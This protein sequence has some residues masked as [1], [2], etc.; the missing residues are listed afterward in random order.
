MYSY[1]YSLYSTHTVQGNGWEIP[2]NNN[3]TQLQA[4][5]AIGAHYPGVHGGPP[6]VD[7]YALLN[8]LSK[9]MW[10]SEDGAESM[11]SLH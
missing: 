3:L 7:E 1:S 10:A 4:V 5:D 2:K 6:P 9:P 11:H 8:S